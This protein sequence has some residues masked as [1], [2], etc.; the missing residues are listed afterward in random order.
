MFALMRER[1]IRCTNGTILGDALVS[2]A[3]SA[4]ASECVR[5]DAD[6]LLMIDSDIVFDPEDAIRLCE[7]VASGYDIIGALTLTRSEDPRAACI[8]ADEVIMA[9]DQDP[10]QAEY[11]HTAFCAT[12]R[13]V[14]DALVPLL[15]L[16]HQN[17]TVI[18]FW[19]F[20]MPMVVPD[21]VEG[22]RYL[23]EDFAL[24][25][26]AKALGF[27]CWIDPTI[28]AGH[29][30]Q[31]LLTLEDLVRPAKQPE[32]AM[33]LRMLPGRILSYETAID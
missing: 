22:Y 31:T 29:L 18:P 16:C 13:R 19:P 9:S 2:R 10:V 4:A 23:S 21:E 14:L 5:S 20:Y 11:I 7:R 26:R 33:R 1:D 17:G 12:S 6:V 24:V 28:R 8:I 25:Q 15:P 32:R 3:R 30:S 27:K